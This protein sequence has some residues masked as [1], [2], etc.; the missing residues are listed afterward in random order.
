MTGIS[1]EIERPGD[2]S[3]L[4]NIDGNF[5]KMAVAIPE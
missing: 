3:L 4:A 5:P 1:D 2:E